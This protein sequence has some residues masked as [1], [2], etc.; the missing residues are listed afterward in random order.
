MAPP[1][2]VFPL[3]PATMAT[4]S[5]LPAFHDGPGFANH[6]LD[7]DVGYAEEAALLAQMKVLKARVATHCAAAE[8]KK[9]KTQTTTFLRDIVQHLP[10]N[11]MQVPGARARILTNLTA[12]A[13]GNI[14][15][16]MP[17]TPA[18]V[19]H[20]NQIPGA[21][22][23]ASLPAPQP[24]AFFPTQYQFLRPPTSPSPAQFSPGSLGWYPAASS[25]YTYSPFQMPS[26]LP[27][28]PIHPYA[29]AVAQYAFPCSSPVT[30]ATPPAGF[31]QLVRLP[32]EF[33]SP[34]PG[35]SQYNDNPRGHKR[36]RVEDWDGSD[37]GSPRVHLHG[38]SSP[39]SISSTPNGPN[40]P[41]IPTPSPG[42]RFPATP[43]HGYPTPQFVVGPPNTPSPQKNNSATYLSGTFR[44]RRSLPQR[45]SRASDPFGALGLAQDEL[46]RFLGGL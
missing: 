46:P 44:A 28:S 34:K 13:P 26:P 12:R 10:E 33:Y 31:G 32:P 30:P 39:A 6:L 41:I 19:P 18:R 14:P 29:G 23:V 7:V 4:H 40:A 20:A 8:R 27:V 2:F 1:F 38:Q 37:Y 42:M 24:P 45:P 9:F 25:P 22:G 16:R 5:P 11:P 43:T 15:V 3:L 17:L 35:H 21:H 36:A